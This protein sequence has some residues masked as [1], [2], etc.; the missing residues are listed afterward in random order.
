MF[1]TK[2]SLKNEIADLM[3]A[4][5]ELDAKYNALFEEAA[6]NNTAHEEER[7]TLCDRVQELNKELKTTKETLTAFRKM[8]EK[9]RK[10]SVDLV[11]EVKRLTDL[12]EEQAKKLSR[13]HC[14]TTAKKW[15]KPSTEATK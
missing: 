4:Y 8:A 12:N 6:K 2:K 15:R 7:R 5:K 10:E 1:R 13:K 11:K 3:Q 14:N 9:Y